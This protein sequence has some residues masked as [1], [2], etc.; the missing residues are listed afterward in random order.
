MTYFNRRRK[1]EATSKSLTSLKEK[2]NVQ[3]RVPAKPTAKDS[4]STYGL[5]RHIMV[6][7]MTEDSIC[8]ELTNQTTSPQ[9]SR[10]RVTNSSLNRRNLLA[11]MVQN[12]LK[13]PS[14]ADGNSCHARSKSSKECFTEDNEMSRRDVKTSYSPFR[15]RTIRNNLI[16][17]SK[18]NE[19]QVIVNI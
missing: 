9:F 6:T 2:Q 5:E 7:E 8:D 19:N 15:R 4:Q 18:K 10:V 11:K 3:I 1:T 14:T 13:V 12:K 17:P 16:G